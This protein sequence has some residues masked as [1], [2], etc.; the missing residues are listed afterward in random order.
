MKLALRGGAGYGTVMAE[1]VDIVGTRYSAFADVT[2]QVQAGGTGSYTVADLQADTGL[3]RYGVWGL[4]IAY[5]DES[6]ILANGATSRSPEQTRVT[7]R[8]ACR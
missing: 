3:G 2:A 4:D 1:K 6:G 8:S 7:R 5:I